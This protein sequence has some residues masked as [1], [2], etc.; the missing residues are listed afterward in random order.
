MSATMSGAVG[1]L[2]MVLSLG[3]L[4]LVPRAKCTKQSLEMRPTPH[5]ITALA[6]YAGNTKSEG[7][8]TYRNTK[9]LTTYT[10][11]PSASHQGQRLRLTPEIGTARA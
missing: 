7:A 11:R 1:Q 2:H 6:S 10:A 4:R 3:A 5:R 8:S 9:T